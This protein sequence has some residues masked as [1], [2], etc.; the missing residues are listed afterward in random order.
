MLLFWGLT[1]LLH[2]SSPIKSWKH[3]HQPLFTV[4]TPTKLCSEHPYLSTAVN[5]YS[6]SSGPQPFWHQGLF[7][8]KTVFHKTGGERMVPGWLKHVTFIVH[9]ISI[10]LTSSLHLRSLGVRSRRL[11]TPALK[12]HG[13]QYSHHLGETPPFVV[14]LFRF[15]VFTLV[16]QSLAFL[17]QRDLVIWAWVLHRPLKQCDWKGRHPI[18][19]HCGG[20]TYLS[21][22]RPGTASVLRR[23]VRRLSPS[24][25]ASRWSLE[26]SPPRLPV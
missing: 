22:I 21:I 24:S 18:R 23:K 26:L 16:T 13:V 17:G 20:V 19:G 8:W 1:T 25:P 10:I 2:P 14:G 7:S 6:L 3:L 15:D 9:V 11:G 12:A 4:K 5:I